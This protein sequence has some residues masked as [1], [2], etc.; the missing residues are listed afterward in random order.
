MTVNGDTI[1]GVTEN[2]HRGAGV[3]QVGT[4]PIVPSAA[5][6]NRLNN[7]IITYVNGTLTVNPAPLTITANNESKPF[8]TVE[9]FSPTAFTE[10]GLVTV[11]GD[12]ITGVTETST[13]APASAP[14][15]TYPIVPSSATGNRLNNYTISYVN[16]T[17]TVNQSIIILDPKA[18]GALSLSGNAAISFAGGVFVDSSSSSALSASGNATVQAS[19]IDVHGG[20]QKSGNAS[21]S[22]APTTGAATLAD[23]LSGLAQSLPSTSGL[24][25]YGSES[26]SGNSSATIKPGI[27]SQISASGNARLTLT[28]GLYII[29]GGG[30]S[31]SGNASVTG[32]GVT[33]FNA[34]SKYPTTG[35]TYGS[36]SLSGNGNVTLSPPTTGTYAGVVIF[37]PADNTKALS[38]S[39]NA[40]S[41]TGEIYAPAAQ[42]NESGNGQLNASIVVDTMTI[43]GNG[44]V[45]ARGAERVRPQRSL[46]PRPRRRPRPASARWMAA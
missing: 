8:G 13:G 14:V 42:L 43:S 9:T 33:I 23:P 20:V 29:E 24:T 46:S 10:F 11:N 17:L 19:V 36:I 3:S 37:Q 31:V 1:T 7:Y 25:N 12:T 18:G 39:G 5:I 32:S 27:Y 40:S 15:G 30:F 22:P 2:Q 41:V 6:G 35:G 44:N 21:F 34:G 16:G 45:E 28:S 4:Y 26:L 38:I